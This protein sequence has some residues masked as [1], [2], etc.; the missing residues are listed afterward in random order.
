MIIIAVLGVLIIMMVMNL[1]L[2]SDSLYS[3]KY[4]SRLQNRE[5]SYYVARSAY[6]SA[7]R[8][9]KLD[10]MKSDGTDSQSS[11]WA[12]DFPELE[13]DEGTIKVRI[14]DENRRFNINNVAKDD[15]HFKQCERLFR[16]Q[17]INENFINAVKDWID[18][19]KETTTPG[20]SETMKDSKLPVKNAPFDSMGELFYI[21]GFNSEWYDASIKQGEAKPG[22]KDL[23]TV[24]GGDKININT[25][26][27]EVLQSLDDSMSREIAVEILSRRKDKAIESMDKLLEVPGI[28]TDILYRM[29]YL[30]DVKS[31]HFRIIV[32]VKKGDDETILEAVV[33]R[34]SGAYQP[35]Y[36]KVE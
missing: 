14:E 30:S 32:S 5:S 11:L 7:L 1:Q 28:T 2:C 20:G 19:D 31:T 18:E 24:Y 23:L 17:E 4:I 13:L 16:N 35:L 10:E 22:L 26:G 6:Q 9:L 12:Q 15:K 3:A 25:A 21:N 29:G 8:I 34:E 36:W 33:K 27:V